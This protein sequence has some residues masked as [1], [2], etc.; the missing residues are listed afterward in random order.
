MKTEMEMEE[1]IV[2]IPFSSTITLSS[3][4][5]STTT[6]DAPCYVMSC[7]AMLYK[8]CTVLYIWAVDFNHVLSLFLFS[9]YLVLPGP[10]YSFL[11]VAR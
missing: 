5:S 8:Y 3:F 9:I 2:I 1:Q 6:L 11:Q 10:P 7:H 4:I